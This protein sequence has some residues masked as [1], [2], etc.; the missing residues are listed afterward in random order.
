MPQPAG[1]PNATELQMLG[2]ARVLQASDYANYGLTTSTTIQLVRLAVK[3][4]KPSWS[5]LSSDAL[6]Y[7]DVLQGTDTDIW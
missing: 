2:S 4:F 1:S 7:P 3:E 6:F 5:F